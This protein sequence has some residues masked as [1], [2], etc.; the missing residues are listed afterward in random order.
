MWKE[1]AEFLLM[2]N[3]DTIINGTYTDIVNAML[4]LAKEV[5]NKACEEQKK[6][7]L[8]HAQAYLQQDD[9]LIISMGSILN[10]PNAKFEV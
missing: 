7:C 5:H 4:Q 2:N 9:E 8:K 3:V 6:I 10:S 1:K